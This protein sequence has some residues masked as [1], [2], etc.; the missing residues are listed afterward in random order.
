M[1]RAWIEHDPP[2]RAR[3]VAGWLVG[4][5]VVGILVAGAWG[6]AEM[7]RADLPDPLAIHWG[8][9][10][11]ADGTATL[12]GMI[13]VTTGLGLAGLLLMLVLGAALLSRP[14]LLRGWMTGLAPVVAI[15][16]VSLLLTLPPNRGAAAWQGAR[17]SSWV[18]VLAILLPGLAAGAAWFAAARPARA[19]T[20]GPQIPDG[21]PVAISRQTYVERQ[22]MPVGLWLAVGM[23]VV[24]AVATMWLGA[25][26]LALGVLVAGILGWL[27]VYVY[28]V[29]DAGLTLTVGPVGPLRWDVP[30]TEI[31]GAAASH[32]AAREW[33]GWGYRTNGRDWAVVLRSGPGARVALAGRRSM[34]LTSD[35]P[36]ELVGRVNAAVSRHWGGR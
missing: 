15:A 6:L 16:P 9:S 36:E 4:V 19:S 22:V 31:E 12:D 25:G 10:G 27:S 8:I 28:R 21:A 32:L 34:S 29:D 7:W 24:T 5:A 17:M 33:G 14:R 26:L 3:V 13:R 2:S 11:A 23:L 18:L 1:A 35:D 30:V 20:V